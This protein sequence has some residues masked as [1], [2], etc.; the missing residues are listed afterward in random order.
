M[1]VKSY[2]YKPKESFL[3]KLLKGCAVLFT[4]AVM[5]GLIYVVYDALNGGS[6]K[7]RESLNETDRMIKEYQ[8]QYGK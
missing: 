8:K 2:S 7:T 4:I 5:C 6:D 3:V 1:N